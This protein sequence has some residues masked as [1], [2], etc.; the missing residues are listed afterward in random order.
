MESAVHQTPTC[1]HAPGYRA[2]SERLRCDFV[3][4]SATAKLLAG[5]IETSFI[6]MAIVAEGDTSVAT[7]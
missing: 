5:T 1:G 4:D 6:A 3:T 7:Q 2:I